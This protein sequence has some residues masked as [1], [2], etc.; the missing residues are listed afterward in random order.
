MGEQDEITKAL[1]W[2][3]IHSIEINSNS[4]KDKSSI[5]LNINIPIATPARFLII[6][7]EPSKEGREIGLCKFAFRGHQ[8]FMKSLP[9]VEQELKLSHSFDSLHRRKSTLKR[10]KRAH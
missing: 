6:Y 10:S 7:V 5:S 3:H 9:H 1:R 8:Y 4:T 2:F